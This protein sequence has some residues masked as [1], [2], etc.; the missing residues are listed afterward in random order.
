MPLHSDASKNRA[1]L[2]AQLYDEWGGYYILQRLEAGAF[3]DVRPLS[4]DEALTYRT[5]NDEALLIV[6]AN[7]RG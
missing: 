5:A 3:V 1:L 7:S 4:R 6:Y 2:V